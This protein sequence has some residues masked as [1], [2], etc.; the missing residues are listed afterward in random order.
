MYFIMKHLK[1]HLLLE[2]VS[3]V[4]VKPGQTLREAFQKALKRRKLLPEM[5]TVYSQEGYVKS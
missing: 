1:S 5:C 4:Q 2:I 3:Q